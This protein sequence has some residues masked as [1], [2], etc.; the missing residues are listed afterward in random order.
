MKATG[1]LLVCGL[2]GLWTAVPAGAADIAG[3]RRA[4]LNAQDPDDLPAF[5]DPPADIAAQREGISRGKLEM[6]EYDSR[7][8]GARRK[9]LVYTPPDYSTDR[10]YPVL[11]LLHGIGCD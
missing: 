3:Q 10:R 11:Y 6:I 5:D 7:T 9:M 8:V 1:I 4:Q 2:V